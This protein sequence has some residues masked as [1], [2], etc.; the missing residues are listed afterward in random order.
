MNQSA[1]SFNFVNMLMLPLFFVAI[2]F[3][4]IRPNA[5]KR[6]QEEEMRR[7]LKVGDEIV[8]IGG[9][10]GR[11]VS[12]KEGADTFVIETGSD[13][14]KMKIKRWAI[15]GHESAQ[16][17]AVRAVDLQNKEPSTTISNEEEKTTASVA[18]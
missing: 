10:V 4:L 8:T 6:K 18:D 17:A 13:R 15:S 12:I 5:K 1:G 11:I 9:I 14:S 3:L 2:Y 7:S 16:Q